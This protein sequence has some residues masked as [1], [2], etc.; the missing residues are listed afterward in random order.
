MFRIGV[1]VNI[2]SRTYIRVVLIILI[3]VSSYRRRNTINIEDFTIGKTI[4]KAIVN[5]FI[6]YR[7]ILLLLEYIAI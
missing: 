1:V 5:N 7:S 4:I 6:A 2:T 3:L